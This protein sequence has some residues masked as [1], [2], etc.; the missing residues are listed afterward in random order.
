MVKGFGGLGGWAFVWVWLMSFALD[1][2]GYG[3]D[4]WR[5]LFFFFSLFFSSVFF[6]GHDWDRAKQK[7][8]LHLDG[9]SVNG[10]MGICAGSWMDGCTTTQS[11]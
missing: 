5:S 4:G 11:H 3:H 8:R 9:D 6:I 2:D 7:F 10:F 1:G